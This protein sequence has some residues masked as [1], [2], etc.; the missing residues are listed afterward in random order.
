MR[1]G[2]VFS[3][4]FISFFAL[5]R[6]ISATPGA[7]AE[8]GSA[9]VGATLSA[10]PDR[11]RPELPFAQ[12]VDRDDARTFG[13]G[14]SERHAAERWFAQDWESAK[15]WIDA[16]PPE[17]RPKFE[18]WLASWALREAGNAGASSERLEWAKDWLSDEVN[19]GRR[20]SLNYGLGRKLVAVMA[21]DDPAAALAWAREKLS[22]QSLA[23]AIGATVGVG[24]AGD[25]VAGKSLVETLPPGGVRLYASRSVAYAM[26][27]DDVIEAFRWAAAEAER[28]GGKRGD[29]WAYFGKAA[30]NNDSEATKSILASETLGDQVSFRGHSMWLLVKA[31]GAGTLDWAKSLGGERG[32][33]LV[34]EGLESWEQQ[35]PAAAKAWIAE[36]ELREDGE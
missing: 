24:F 22:G 35:D 19:R 34:K 30:A 33:A 12:S 11:V 16:L 14:R 27:E 2:L 6:W 20:A 5:A 17:E 13:K 21:K 23:K 28:S 26:I 25:P 10:I 32:E 1:L 4:V 18:W 29:W 3:A 7:G 36:N 9:A 15:A 8:G 31:D